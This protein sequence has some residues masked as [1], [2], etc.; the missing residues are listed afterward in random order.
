MPQVQ[1]F[2]RRIPPRPTLAE[3]GANCV[4]QFG[5]RND[6]RVQ[7][8]RHTVKGGL[9]VR[10]SKR[11]YQNHRCAEEAENGLE[12]RDR[13]GPNEVPRAETEQKLKALVAAK[14]DPFRTKHGTIFVTPR[15]R[16]QSLRVAC[17]D[18]ELRK[19]AQIALLFRHGTQFHLVQKHEMKCVDERRADR[20]NGE[21]ETAQELGQIEIL[22]D[23]VAVQFLDDRLNE[24]RPFEGVCRAPHYSN[25]Q[26]YKRHTS[27]D[28]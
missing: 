16:I 11:D 7:T 14:P 6:D 10:R 1:Q 28:G 23:V 3:K 4:S 19:L 15:R 8:F 18:D 25:H 26:N 9:T 21:I 2:S 5:L 13:K 27:K 12:Q 17:T 22:L 20:W 24:H